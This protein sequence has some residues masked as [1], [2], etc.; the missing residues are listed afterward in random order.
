MDLFFRH[1]IRNEDGVITVD[2]TVISAAAVGIA[3]AA[4]AVLT[5]GIEFITSRIDEELRERQLNDTYIAFESAHFEALYAANLVTEAE[6][7]ELWNAAN[8]TMNQNL[9]DQ[10]E[11]GITK[12]Q[13]GTIT[14]EEMGALF[15]AA[16]VA[17]QRNIID[18]AVLE[19]YFGF[20]GGDPAMV[21]PAT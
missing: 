12:I 5:G 7:A 14:Q 3:L 17:Y 19:Y 6:A 15:A 1:F 10:L 21:N 18:D 20:G 16:S 13:D 11:E 4:T 9:I 2:Y 8:S